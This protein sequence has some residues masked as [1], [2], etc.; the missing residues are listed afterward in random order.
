MLQLV[1]TFMIVFFS[2]FFPLINY[3]LIIIFQ[4][5]CVFTD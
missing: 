5:L 3:N 2:F 1:R 4:M